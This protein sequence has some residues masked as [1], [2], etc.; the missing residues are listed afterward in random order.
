M[1]KMLLVLCCFTAIRSYATTD[2]VR[3]DDFQFSPA[4]LNVTVGDVIHFVWV[5][6]THTTTS[7]SIPVGA[8]SWNSPIDVSNTSFD[9]SVTTA[10]TYSY[11]CNFHAFLG[12]TATFTASGTLPITLSAF[13]IIT[14]NNIPQLS[15]STATEVN[16]DHFSIRRSFDGT[17]FKEVGTILASGTS[18]PTRQYSFTD[19]KLPSSVT[20]VY[21]EL[22]TIDKDGQVELSP[23]KMYKNNLAVPR[24]II[25]LSP[26]PVGSMGHVTLQYNSESR[27]I[28]KATLIDMQGKTI[29]ETTL[30]S[31]PGINNGHIH[32]MGLTPGI[33]TLHF[34]LN[35]MSESYRLVKD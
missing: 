35:G 5:S 22:A 30:S 17:N 12:M 4:T 25:S 1:K 9:V 31:E 18:S 10:G 24:L 16:A 21:Y 2:T 19:N 28:M 34:T 14:K 27:G 32:L 7:V 33:Y 15:W 3:V 6:G 20:Y 13:N 11:Q 8:S 26:N 23:I 29:L